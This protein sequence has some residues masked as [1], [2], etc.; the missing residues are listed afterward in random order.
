MRRKETFTLIELMLVVVIIGAL[1]A[2]VVP[3]YLG[4]GE[5]AKKAAAKGDITVISG[6]LDVF[7]LEN[8]KLPSTSDGLDALTQKPSWAKKW[9][10]P[11]LKK[12]PVDPWGNEYEYVCPGRHGPDFDLHSLGPDGKDGGED[13]I[14]SWE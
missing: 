3:R 9:D 11:Y 7:V 4:W 13:D 2:M 5:K 1:A 8:G 6:A 12:S 14:V 10:G